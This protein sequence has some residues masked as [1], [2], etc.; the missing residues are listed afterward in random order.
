MEAFQLRL[1]NGRLGRWLSP[2]PY[3]QYDSPYLGMGNNPISMIDPDGG[4]TIDP[5]V[6]GGQL[7]E[8]V[9]YSGKGNNNWLQQIRATTSNWANE[10]IRIPINNSLAEFRNGVAIA[11]QVNS[12]ILHENLSPLYKLQGQ[13]GGTAGSFM[14]GRNLMYSNASKMGGLADDVAKTFQFGRYSEM[15][16]EEPM[17]LAR[18]YDNEAAFAKGRFMTNSTSTSKFLDRMRLAL[19]PS[20]NGMTKVA[21]WEIPAGTTVYK[22]KAA[23]QFPWIGGQTQYFIPELGN[24]NRVM[25]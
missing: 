9:V 14:A 3:G 15:V 2:D 5:P 8:V 25:R 20:W 4:Q 10:N 11:R 23:M 19:R 22:G 18:Y 17:I 6:K 21:H 24:I 16:L 7:K 1:W 12:E 13:F